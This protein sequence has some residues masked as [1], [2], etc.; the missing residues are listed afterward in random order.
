MVYI[1][2]VNG[3]GGDPIGEEA[4]AALTHAAKGGR[5]A[6]AA[7]KASFARIQAFKSRFAASLPQQETG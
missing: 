2:G 1:A 4:V 7:L 6:Q 3:G 5:L